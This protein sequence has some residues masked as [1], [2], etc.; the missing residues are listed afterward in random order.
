[1]SAVPQKIAATGKWLSSAVWTR[2]RS[3]LRCSY[4]VEE[5]LSDHVYSDDWL[6]E[7][8]GLETSV[9]R[10]TFAKENL[11]EYWRTFRVEIG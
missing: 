11:R 5:R 10:E 1:M 8:G 7:Q 9:S 2:Y 6:P 3:R 4:R